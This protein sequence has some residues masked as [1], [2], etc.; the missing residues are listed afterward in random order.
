MS[1]P[2]RHHAGVPGRDE[3]WVWQIPLRRVAGEPLALTDG[4]RRVAADFVSAAARDRFIASRTLMRECLGRLLGRDPRAVDLVDSPDGKPALAEPVLSFNVAHA[5][6]LVLIAV[7]R[8]RRLGVDVEQIRPGVD[9]RA[10][11]E[12]ALGAA[13]RETV[14]RAVEREG[15]RAFFRY[16]TRYEAV[17][18]AR[19]DGLCLPLPDL[20]QVAAGFAIRELDVPPGYVGAVAADEGPWEIVPCA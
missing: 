9:V 4:E 7:S 20:P 14:T 13:D 12:E 17:V 16:W 15:V 6:A 11:T 2:R 5:G 3:I 8:P 1:S 19:G 18:K 10:I